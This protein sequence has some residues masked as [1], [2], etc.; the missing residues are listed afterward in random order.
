MTTP[1]RSRPGALAPL[2]LLAGCVT[3]SEFAAPPPSAAWRAPAEA[4]SRPEGPLSIDEAVRLALRNSPDLAVARARVESARA[5]VDAARAAF[6]PTLSVDLSGLGGDAPSAYLFKT[7]DARNL[8]P[9]T[10]FNRPGAFSNLEAGATLRWNLWNGGRDLL[11]RWAAETDER[12]A[13]AGVDAVRNA[14]VAGVV[15]AC[16]SARAARE[17]ES[18]EES[19]IAA[20][21][22]QVRETRVKFEG[23]SALR[24]DLLSLEVRL[25]QAKEGRIRAGVGRRLALA[26]LRHLLA[27]PPAGEIEL[28]DDRFD[29]GSLPAGVGD[30]LAEAFDRRP[31]AAGAR[32]AVERARIE[33]ERARRTRLPRLDLESRLYGDDEG[34]SFD[35]NWTVALL[36]GWTP[37]DGG[38]RRAGERRAQAALR[39]VEARD[40]KAIEEI[41]F[42]VESCWLR[43]E[44]SGARLEVASAAV[45]AAEETLDL[46]GR[47]FSGGGVTVTR[48]LEAEQACTGAR[49]AR[50]AAQL[51]LDR[52]RVDLA[53]AMGRFGTEEVR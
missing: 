32:L 43:L 28:A 50:I 39:E 42:D 20:V 29:P 31:E 8:S 47:Q 53:R 7:I 6:L 12:A 52:A 22:S 30:A 21:E 35:R 51:D 23:G 48:F 13:A 46:V 41:A 9:A 18:A 15:A 19:S 11:E 27:L 14:L 4:A 25:A 40:R 38:A 45:G 24:S 26:T 16:L 10:D 17:L 49:T 44:E 5:G 37:Y 3:R 2:L 34:V 1:I 33:F 36:L